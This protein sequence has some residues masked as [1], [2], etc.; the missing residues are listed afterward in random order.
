MKKKIWDAKIRD[1]RTVSLK[2][3]EGSLHVYTVICEVK[4]I[5][6]L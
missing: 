3:R 4:I 6:Y 1:Q 5:T 2:A